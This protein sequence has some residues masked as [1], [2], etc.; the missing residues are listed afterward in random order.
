[1]PSRCYLASLTFVALTGSFNSKYFK[2]FFQH[3][4][5]VR[6]GSVNSNHLK[7]RHR[8]VLSTSADRRKTGPLAACKT[9][10]M[11]NI[12]LSAWSFGEDKLST[13]LVNAKS[14]V[15]IKQ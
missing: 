5:A 8:P 14:N 3:I 13:L 9:K 7:C 4:G 15:K 10:Q 1:M 6:S 11:S 12:Q 2:D